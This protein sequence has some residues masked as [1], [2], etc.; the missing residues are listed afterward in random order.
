MMTPTCW[1]EVRRACCADAFD[2]ED[3]DEA[4]Q[5]AQEQDGTDDR[6]L[7]KEQLLYWEVSIALIACT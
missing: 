6:D 7:D 5:K 2:E 1:L 4:E 3:E